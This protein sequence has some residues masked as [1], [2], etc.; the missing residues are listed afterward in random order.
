MQPGEA[1][2]RFRQ[3]GWAE[4]VA[5]SMNVPFIHVNQIVLSKY[6]GMEP[7]QIMEKYFTPPGDGTHTNPAGAELNA[8]CAAEGLHGLEEVALKDYLLPAPTAA[9]AAAEK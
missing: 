7:E 9:G 6:A 8:L 2:T 5:R 4:E 3:V 1:E